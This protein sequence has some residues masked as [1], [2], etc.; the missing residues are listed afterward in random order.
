MNRFSLLLF[1]IFIKLR[2]KTLNK[3]KNVNYKYKLNYKVENYFYIFKNVTETYYPFNK[4]YWGMI[5]FFT[6]QFQIMY[7]CYKKISCFFFL[8]VAKLFLQS[9]LL[10][11]ILY[12]FILLVIL[13]YYLLHFLVSIVD[14][15]VLIWYIF[16]A[17][18]F[19]LC[20]I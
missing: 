8:K 17:P 2:G 3:I 16:M 9:N 19:I 4:R 6:L 12:F 10:G 1:S 18:F 5:S 14:N 20:L 13:N 11:K 7:I 15:L